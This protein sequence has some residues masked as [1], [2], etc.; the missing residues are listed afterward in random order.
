MRS[1]SLV[2]MLVLA[3]L[4]LTGCSSDS[5]L[6][7]EAASPTSATQFLAGKLFL[8]VDVANTT[9]SA[10]SLDGTRL[11]TTTT[12]ATGNYYLR[13]ALPADF[14]MVA[15]IPGITPPV[16]TEVRGFK[17]RG[18]VVLNIPNTLVSQYM[19]ARPG[20]AWSRRRPGLRPS[21]R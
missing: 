13:T 19:A 11:A 20:P 9:V 21:S 4:G 18:Y 2:L 7:T 17:E 12:D 8:G 5:A 14:R 6:V 16:A 3:V 1:Y 10:V 15:E